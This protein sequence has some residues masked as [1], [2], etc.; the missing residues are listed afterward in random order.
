MGS[1]SLS[2][3]ALVYLT[4]IIITHGRV[5]EAMSTVTAMARD[6]ISCTMCSA[7]SNPR[8]P[9]FPP[10][11]PPPPSPSPPPPSPPPQIPESYCP[12]PPP[13]PP[14]LPECPPPPP[15]SGSSYYS[16]PPPGES[17]NPSPA[18]GGGGGS[19]YPP[20]NQAVPYYPYYNYST[21]SISVALKREPTVLCLLTIIFLP[22][23]FI[24]LL[25]T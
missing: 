8:Q 1:L 12:P 17:S 15:S 16:P 23:V 14:L 4:G 7:C 11:P 2:F 22:F 24:S 13:Q 10:P 25:V 3:T 20:P 6:Q 21:P 18:A 5:S 9:I 19:Y